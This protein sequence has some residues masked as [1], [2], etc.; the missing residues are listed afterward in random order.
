MA[1]SHGMLW[2]L[3]EV[4]KEH[5]HRRHS[6]IHTLFAGFALCSYSPPTPALKASMSNS[7]TKCSKN[8]FNL[9]CFANASSDPWDYDIFAYFY[10]IF[11]QM[12]YIDSVLRKMRAKLHYFNKIWQHH[13]APLLPRS[14]GNATD[15]LRANSMARKSDNLFATKSVSLNASYPASTF[16]QDVYGHSRLYFSC[17]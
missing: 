7:L 12:Q 1:L 15:L 16:E 2:D 17:G 5:R 3:S 10:P 11:Y 14:A 6:L 13:L 4:I 8:N 9:T